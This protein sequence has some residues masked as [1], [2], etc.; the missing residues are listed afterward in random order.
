MQHAE[1]KPEGERQHD[2]DYSIGLISAGTMSDRY[3][4]LMTCAFPVDMAVPP[5]SRFCRSV[6]STRFWDG[7][8]LYCFLLPNYIVIDCNVQSLHCG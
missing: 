4:G 5:T 2:S 3:G 8:C 7:T 1:T 6:L